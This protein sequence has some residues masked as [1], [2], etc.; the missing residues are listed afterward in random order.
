MALLSTLLATA[1]KTSA[2]PAIGRAGQPGAVIDLPTPNAQYGA[3]RERERHGT[4]PSAGASVV[5]RGPAVGTVHAS[6]SWGAA[7]L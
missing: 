7:S 4:T 1:A 5:F 6:G 2:E 3:L